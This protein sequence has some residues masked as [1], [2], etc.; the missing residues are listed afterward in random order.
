MRLL[1]STYP[2]PTCS[3]P[4]EQLGLFERPPAPRAPVASLARGG[5]LAVD[6]IERVPWPN[7]E[8]VDKTTKKRVVRMRGDELG[9]R[10]DM[11]APYR[12][13]RVLHW[14]QPS[15]LDVNGAPYPWP[16]VLDLDILRRFVARGALIVVNDSGGKDSQVMAILLARVV[17]RDQILFVHAVLPE[18]EW[19]GT[20]EHARAHAQAAGAPFLTAQA[21]KTFLGMA[22]EKFKRIPD[23]PSWPTPG[24]RQCTSDLKRG[25]LE[26]VILNYAKHHGF[27]VI[28]NAM[29]LRSLESPNR[30]RQAVWGL[31][32]SKTLPN[33]KHGWHP[34]YPP[35][36]QQRV[37]V[38][39]LPIHH[40]TRA[41]VF[42]TIAAAGQRPHPAYAAGNE[43]LS[44]VFCIVAKAKDLRTGALHYP[45][46]FER[47]DE[48]ETRMGYGLHAS[49]KTLREMTGLTPAQAKAQRRILPVLQG[50]FIPPNVNDPESGYEAECGG[51]DVWSEEDGE[52]PNVPPPKPPRARNAKKAKGATGEFLTLANGPRTPAHPMLCA[53]HAH[54]LGL[55]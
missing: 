5:I 18:V 14:P 44:C 22:E 23:K 46:L 28:V 20:E 30:S 39:Y 40:L 41:Q 49:K 52:H 50:P 15:M 29:G 19:E 25:P 31:N 24:Q 38:N 9:A 4:P 34:P 45:E 16:M 2:I 43:R 42:Y 33:P 10:M 47:V 11:A 51:D 35:R 32:A 1:P 53:R 8:G 21:G 55:P 54:A 26:R 6:P 36:Q 48:M 7:L 17:P 13:G 37:W 3:N 27:S 12:P